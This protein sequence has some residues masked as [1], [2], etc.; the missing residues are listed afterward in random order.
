MKIKQLLLLLLLFVYQYG[1]AC[2]AC[3]KQQPK[4]IQNFTH[5]TGPGSS[6]D[7]V[8]VSI[9]AIITLLTLVYSLKYLFKPGEK[10]SDHIKQSILRF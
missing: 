7:W 9:I 8:I 3:K 2:E 6:W 5:G 10:N 1:I 4:I